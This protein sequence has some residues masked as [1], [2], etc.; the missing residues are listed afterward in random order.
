MFL[1][2]HATRSLNT[3][4][5][6]EGPGTL[7]IPRRTSSA[8]IVSFQ[9]SFSLP[10]ALDLLDCGKLEETGELT[11]WFMIQIIVSGLVNVK[12]YVPGLSRS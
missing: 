5:H 10:V 2:V 11:S 8:L 12:A 9:D 4:A 3:E 7:S 6:F 1:G